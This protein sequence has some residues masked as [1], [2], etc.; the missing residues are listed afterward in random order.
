MQIRVTALFGHL[1]A[2]HPGLVTWLF[3]TLDLLSLDPGRQQPWGESG[4]G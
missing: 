3:L 4:E 1:L 2:G